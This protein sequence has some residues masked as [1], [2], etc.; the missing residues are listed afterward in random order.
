MSVVDDLFSVRGQVALVTGG[1]SGL[2]YAFSS[3]LADAGATVVVA[4]W[5][6]GGLEKSVAA[7]GESAAAAGGGQVSGGKLDVSDHA[8]VHAFVDGIVAEHGRIDIAF[9]N[10]GV[11]RGRP[12][13]LA[14]GWL[15][16]MSMTDYNA[17]IDVNLHGAVYTVQAAAKHMKRQKSGSIVTTA[18]TAGLRNDPYTPYSYTI[19]KAAVINFT[20]QAAHD[21]ARWGVRVN[22]I[23]PGPFKTNL[24]GKREPTSAD[25]EAMWRSVVPL[26]RM[27]TP[28]EIR[29]LALLLASGAGSFMTGGVYPIDGGALLQGPSLPPFEG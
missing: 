4:D 10:A 23:A 26:G 21:L 24:G 2:G 19:A 15:D 8:A 5:D 20:K 22:A 29:G 11:A 17:L 13:L 16:D 25:A 28:P 9:A 18:S 6:A 1:A 3:I 7:L 27:G 12:P 14:E